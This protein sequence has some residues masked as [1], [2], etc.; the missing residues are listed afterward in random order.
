MRT[1]GWYTIGWIVW[2]L[3]FV[4]LEGSAL[5]SRI[6][7]TTLSAHVWKITKVADPRPTWLVW[8][9]RAGFAVLGLW[10]GGHFAMGWWSF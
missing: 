4:G 3:L 8:M 9:V 5:R 7:G 2:G 10:L 6:P 1:E